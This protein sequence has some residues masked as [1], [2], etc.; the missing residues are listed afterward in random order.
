MD[1]VERCKN[2]KVPESDF[3]V[4]V[5]AEKYNKMTDKEWEKLIKRAAKDGYDISSVRE[6]RRQYGDSFNVM[7]FSHVFSYI[8]EMNGDVVRCM[9]DIENIPSRKEAHAAIRAAYKK[10][11]VEMSEK[12]KAFYGVD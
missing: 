11:G 2:L 3:N 1:F 6:Y 9:D 12:E 10:Y 7:N 8:L 4:I 5:F